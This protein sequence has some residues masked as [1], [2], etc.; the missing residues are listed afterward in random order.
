MILFWEM[1]CNL[2]EMRVLIYGFSFR[3]C[4]KT[5]I[6]LRLRK[7]ASLRG[8]QLFTGMC[9]TSPSYKALK[10]EKNRDI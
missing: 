4:C 7:L 1:N 8:M 9:F 2:D 10:D 5:R 6:M 3:M